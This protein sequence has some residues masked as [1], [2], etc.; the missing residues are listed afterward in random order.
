MKLIYTLVFCCIASVSVAQT[1]SPGCGQRENIVTRLADKYNEKPIARGLETGGTRM[2][3]ILVSPKGSFTVLLT[4]A[5]G[6]SCIAASG[7]GW[8]SVGKITKR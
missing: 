8:Q 4:Y 5:N 2:I 7:E 1:T 3:E 6:I